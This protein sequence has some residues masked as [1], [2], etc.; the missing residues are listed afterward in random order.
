V[1]FVP[2]RSRGAAVRWCR[3]LPHGLLSE[4]SVGEI[5]N[6]TP[7]SPQCRSREM[8]VASYRCRPWSPPVVSSNWHRERETF[9]TVHH[10]MCGPL[11]GEK[12]PGRLPR[13]RAPTGG[14]IRRG[15]KGGTRKCRESGQRGKRVTPL[16]GRGEWGP[17]GGRATKTRPERLMRREGAV[18]VRTINREDCR[19]HLVEQEVARRLSR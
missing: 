4:P 13:R 17:V 18:K 7:G 9:Q 2:P 8:E 15:K 3:V 14:W 10:A 5:E 11:P 12:I 1:T 6:S 16:K 19:I